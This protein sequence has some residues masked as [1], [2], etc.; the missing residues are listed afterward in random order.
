MAACNAAAVR[1]SWPAPSSSVAQRRAAA[2]SGGCA[3][4]AAPFLFDTMPE[5]AFFGETR[6]RLLAL[7]DSICT[8]LS[9]LDGQRFARDEW[10]RSEGGGGVSRVLADGGL[11]EKAAV[12]FSA[13]RGSRLPD[14]VLKEQPEVPSGAEYHAAGVS[15]ICHP[16]NPHVPTVHFNV[17][18]FECGPAFWYGGGMDLTPYYPVRQDCVDFHR[19]IKA[20][21]DRFDPAYYPDY[22]A[23]CD[24]YFFIKH[25]A[26]AR[27]V[28]GI[29]FNYLKGDRERGRDFILALG[30]TFLTAYVPI[31]ERRAAVPFGE[32]ERAF[33]LY[34]R[35][36]Y[37]E[38]NLMYDQGTLFG[39]Q[40]GGRIESILASLPPLAAWAY[41]WQPDPRSPEAS[42]VRDFLP[43]QD[44]V[45]TD[46]IDD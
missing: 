12:L 35:G 27:G 19:A 28:G 29:F 13:I 33:Q 46:G 20:C 8:E 24:R 43:P 15:L 23:W 38:F 26:E 3:T 36:R 30:Q 17:R 31:V 6:S 21:C 5:S 14:T 39:L 9:R 16:R 34:R 7:Q 25:R 40:S 11:F 44:W 41:D 37:V 18:Y 45:R 1:P 32:R 4:E 10:E 42:L 2:K 22:K